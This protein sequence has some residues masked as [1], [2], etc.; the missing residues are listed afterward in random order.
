M[1]YMK[2]TFFVFIC[3]LLFAGWPEGYAG[4]ITDPEADSELK[5]IWNGMITMLM[6][7]D[8][9]KAVEYFTHSTRERYREQFSLIADRLPVIFSGMRDI[10]PIYIKGD[11]AKYR[12]RINDNGRE[13]TGYI[14]FR[15][16]MLGRWKIEKF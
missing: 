4:E 14:W 7:K 1:E 16:D 9:E 10:E 13:R 2:K 11:E 3:L 12:V 6:E 5:T 15:S 8:I